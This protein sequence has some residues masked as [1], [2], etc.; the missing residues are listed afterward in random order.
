MVRGLNDLANVVFL[1]RHNCHWGNFGHV[2]ATLK[3][4]AW[5]FD[6]EVYFDYL[7][8][9]TGQDY[10]IK[11]N[12]CIESFLAKARERE[13]ISYYPFPNQSWG[14]DG[15]MRRIE[16]WHFRALEDWHFK[17]FRRFA[18]LPLKTQSNSRIKTVACWLIN[19]AFPKRKL[20]GNM[21]PFGGPG[22]WCITRECA[23]YIYQ[24]ARDNPN[25]VRFCKYVDIPDEVFFHTI[26]MNSPFAQNVVNNDLR[27]IDISAGK[28]PKI[29][30]K[31]DFDALFQSSA[32]IARKFDPTVDSEI[33]DLIDA[34]LLLNPQ[35]PE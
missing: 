13:F 28:G 12:A 32:L 23:K 5:L 18:H 11:S 33:L 31:Q 20:P 21:R 30:T 16:L 22:Y 29:W 34:K 4:L 2:R 15:G 6:N 10:P 35:T 14:G 17:I 26:I 7:F 27:C 19:L 8:L 9:L 24:F 1:K 25:F 3:G